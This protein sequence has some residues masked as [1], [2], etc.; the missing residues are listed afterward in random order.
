MLYNKYV[1]YLVASILVFVILNL[2]FSGPVVAISNFDFG[3]KN[4]TIFIEPVGKM[5]P[6]WI[7]GEDTEPWWENIFD[8]KTGFD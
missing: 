4:N 1:R 6:A 3:S 7:T 2:F 8:K 5:P